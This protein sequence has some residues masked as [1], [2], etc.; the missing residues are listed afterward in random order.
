M[1]VWAGVGGG[2]IGRVVLIFQIC[3]FFLGQC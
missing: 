1:C 2:G 3:I